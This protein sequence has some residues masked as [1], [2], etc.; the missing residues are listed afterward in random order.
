MFSFK[1]RRPLDK[2]I[3]KESP[4]KNESHPILNHNKTK[5][6]GSAKETTHSPIYSWVNFCQL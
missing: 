2:F 3:K 1:E 5:Y 4:F 6:L